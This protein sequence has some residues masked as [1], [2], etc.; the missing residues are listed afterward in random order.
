VHNHLNILYYRLHTLKLNTFNLSEPSFEEI[1]PVC[2]V[3][4]SYLFSI[5]L[6]VFR[7]CNLESVEIKIERILNRTTHFLT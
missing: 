6:V 4:P 5:F 2:K 1:Q 7:I 3:L